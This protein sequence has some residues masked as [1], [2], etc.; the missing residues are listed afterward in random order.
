[1]SK[2][3]VNFIQ[4]LYNSKDNIPLHEPYFD[5]EEE[6]ALESVIKSTFVSSVGP[7]VGEFESRISEYTGS[8]YTT[9][10]M[11]GTCAL[12]IAI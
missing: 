8:K 1:M 3:L 7:L 6:K 12:Q 2:N 5:S 4:D 11:N 9:A 10:V